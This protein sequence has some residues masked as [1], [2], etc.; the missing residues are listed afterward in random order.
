MRWLGALAVVLVGA[1][2]Y[3]YLAISDGSAKPSPRATSPEPAAAAG[4]VEAVTPPPTKPAAA[5]LPPKPIA[6][7]TTT[8]TATRPD[9]K[10]SAPSAPA[11]EEPPPKNA[12]AELGDPDVAWTEQERQ[13]WLWTANGRFEKG[14]YPRALEAALEIARRNPGSA[15][16][17]DAWRVAIKSHCAMAEPE[18]ATALF[19]KMTDQTGIEE[20]TKACAEWNV[21]LAK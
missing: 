2:I 9:S 11:A 18:K 4:E 7:P 12:P 5:P 20:A 10:S 17:Q 8:T 21:K 19:A 16:E 15:W 6:I 14:N 3:L 13:Q 1:A